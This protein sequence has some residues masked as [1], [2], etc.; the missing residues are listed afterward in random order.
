MIRK[1]IQ[2]KNTKERLEVMAS[3][4]MQDWTEPELDTVMK[5]FGLKMSSG[6]SME[7]KWNMI[8]L[9]LSNRE[10]TQEREIGM[11]EKLF[12][13]TDGVVLSDEELGNVGDLTAYIKS[14]QEENLLGR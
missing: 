2:C 12:Q 4:K 6:A 1:F 13:D 9:A 10:V 8:L 3:S 14:C 7:D 11:E 5:I